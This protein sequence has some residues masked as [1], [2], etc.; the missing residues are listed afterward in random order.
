MNQAI[1]QSKNDN[2]DTKYWDDYFMDGDLKNDDGTF[3]NRAD[4]SDAAFE[5]YLAP[6]LKIVEKRTVTDGNNQKRI[7]YY[8]ADGSAFAYAY[9]TNR[10]FQF[11]PKNA[12]KCIM[13]S[14]AYSRGV[15][16]FTFVFYP[17]SSIYSW[18]YHYNKGMEPLLVN[19]DG[20]ESSLYDASNFG[21]ITNGG[22]CTA[23]IARNGWKIPKDYPKRIKF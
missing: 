3:V 5:K 15:C 6:Y 20:Q 17:N 13:T 14:L 18:K 2:G 9:Q 7:L 12:E 23:I 21:C 19:W 4:E 10:N 1:L 8:L 11:F 16:L 22:Y